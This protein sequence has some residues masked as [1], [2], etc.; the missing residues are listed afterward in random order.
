MQYKVGVEVVGSSTFYPCSR[1]L[2]MNLAYAAR[3]TSPEHIT[4]SQLTRMK[5]SKFK[6]P[7][8][9]QRALGEVTFEAAQLADRQLQGLKTF[10]L[11]LLAEA[12][13]HNLVK[14][15]RESGLDIIA[16]KMEDDVPE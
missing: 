10:Q 3:I 15:I 13:Y 4:C 11:L 9:K 16:D 14:T 1:C 12:S 7:F 6:L 2:G 5:S 8:H